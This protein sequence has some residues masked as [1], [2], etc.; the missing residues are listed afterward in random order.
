MLDLMNRRALVLFIQRFGRADLFTGVPPETLT[1]WQRN[2]GL[3]VAVLDRHGL[4]WRERYAE[5]LS[6]VNEK[7]DLYILRDWRYTREEIQAFRERHAGTPVLAMLF[8]APE[9]FLQAQQTGEQEAL[10]R[11]QMPAVDPGLRHFEAGLFVADR[12]IVRSRLNAELFARLGYPHEKMVLLPH[13]PAWTWQGE[14]IVPLALDSAGCPVERDGTFN[15]LCIGQD[16]LRKGILRLYRAFA[17]L[18]IPGKRLHLYNRSLY[19]YARGADADFPAWMM[20]AIQ[21]MLQDPAV[22]IHAPYRGLEFVQA[23]REM[24]LLVCPSLLDCGPNV[25]VEAYQL[26]TPVLA[27]TLCGSVFDLPEGAVGL[28][29]APRWWEQDEAAEAFADRLARRITD[30][31]QRERGA[32]APCRPDVAPMLDTIVQTWEH[33]LEEYL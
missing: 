11:L 12:V 2:V 24:H 20:P 8:R 22:L 25:L 14:R 33:L 23:H 13:A 3:L 29:P 10:G 16:M 5:H 31:Y 18:N 32:F 27:S 17:R 9:Y 28:V 7:A 4:A 1:G 26:G 19:E 15:L 6:E 30:F 21:Q